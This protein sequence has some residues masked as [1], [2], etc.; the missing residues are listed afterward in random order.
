[1]QTDMY[2]SKFMIVDAPAVLDNAIQYLPA[3]IYEQYSILRSA[4]YFIEVLNT[5]VNKGKCCSKSR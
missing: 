1:M 2:F 3:N 5:H 4:P